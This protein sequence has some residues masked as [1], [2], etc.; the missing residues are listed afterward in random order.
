MFSGVRQR[1]F[2][3]KVFQSKIPCNFIWITWSIETILRLFIS[4]F[5]QN[6]S[7][8][9]HKFGNWSCVVE[10]KEKLQ[11][12]WKN[13]WKKVGGVVSP[14][15]GVVL[16]DMH[17]APY[18]PLPHLL[19]AGRYGEH[20][21]ITCAVCIGNIDMASIYRYDPTVGNTG[22]TSGCNVSRKCRGF[23]ETAKEQRSCQTLWSTIPYHPCMV[24]VPTF[25]WSLW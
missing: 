12:N 24:Y 8:D 3:L 14:P 22:N 6:A 15:C 2:F 5:R 18:I 4:T 7:P 20:V 17:H 16:Q 23:E 10:F 21:R 19:Q 1:R 25:G 11:R 13:S 9:R